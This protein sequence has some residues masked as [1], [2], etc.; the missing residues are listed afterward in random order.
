MRIK[1]LSLAVA[2]VAAAAFPGTPASAD[3]TGLNSCSLSVGGAF[4]VATCDYVGTGAFTVFDFT[5]ISGDV[6]ATV[7]CPTVNRYYDY[8]THE[9][10]LTGPTVCHI[11]LFQYVPGSGSGSMDV[12]NKV[13]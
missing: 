6:D 4:Q 5:Q 1:A 7:S 13:S 10:V 9:E 3:P 11:Q 2:A 8:S 12:Y